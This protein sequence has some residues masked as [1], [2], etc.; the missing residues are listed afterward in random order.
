MKRDW[1]KVWAERIEEWKQS[2]ASPSVFCREHGLGLSSFYRWKARLEILPPGGIRPCPTASR[3]L[4]E[5]LCKTVSDDSAI[6]ALVLRVD[7]RYALELGQG[8]DEALLL[9][10]LKVLERL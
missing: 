4:V 6:P 5:V 9:R 2:G 3:R 1:A 7:S 8:F 10:T